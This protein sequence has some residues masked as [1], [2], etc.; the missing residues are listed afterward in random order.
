MSYMDPWQKL[1]KRFV[2]RAFLSECLWKQHRER[3]RMGR[4]E[5]SPQVH[6]PQRL[7]TGLWKLWRSLMQPLGDVTLGKGWLCVLP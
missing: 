7:Q 1:R 4:G 6:L 5:G 3:G 2:C